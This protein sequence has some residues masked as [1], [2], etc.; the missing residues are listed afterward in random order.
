MIFNVLLLLGGVALLVAMLHDAFEVMLLPR[1]VKSK[2]RI[3]RF[4]FNVTWAFWAA[5][6]PRFRSDDAR[7]NFLGLYGPLSLVL[8][9]MV[10]A[11]GIILAFSFINWGLSP[12][13]ISFAGW[14]NEAYFS[15]ATF[16]TL[17]YG[18]IVPKTGLTKVLSVFEA[19][20]GLGF[21]AMVIGYLPVFYQLFSRREAH[22]ITLDSVAGSPPSAV[23]VLCRYSEGRSLDMLDTFLVR[24]QH[25]CAEVL[26]SQLS[27]PMLNYY[28]SQHENQSWLAALTAVT[29]VCALVMVGLTGVR[30][31]QAR[32]TF[33][34]ARLTLIEIGRVLDVGPR[35]IVEDRLPPEQFVCLVE[36]FTEADLCFADPEEA[37]ARLASF[38]STYEPF[39]NGL[40][41]HLRLPLSQFCADPS[42]LDNWVHTPRGRSAKRLIETVPAEP[43]TSEES[44]QRS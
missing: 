20:T 36:R 42:Q 37:E 28:R 31:M 26:E 29:D 4:F 43:A 27:Y 16:F 25:W 5:L 24:W 15:G 3:V 40:A 34:S 2:L 22:V 6:A 33:A 44:E 10:W 9:L 17:G 39:L 7:E 21:I 23:T 18:D 35:S 1:R 14:L 12:T 38:R 13:S 30:T 41:H 11:I 32:L 19:G 8:L